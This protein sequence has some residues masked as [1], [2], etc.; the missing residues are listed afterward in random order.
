M[1]TSISKNLSVLLSLWLIL[2]SSS[3]AL[4]QRRRANTPTPVRQQSTTAPAEQAS[5]AAC[6]IWSGTIE[7]R[8]QRRESW[9]RVI[10]Q[11]EH[12]SD[13]RHSGT[14]ETKSSYDYTASFNVV[15]S[16]GNTYE[17]GSKLV[18]LKG[19]IDAEALRVDEEK[20]SWRTET[21]CFP[22]TPRIRT[23]GKNS[24]SIITESGKLPRTSGDGIM[25]IRGTQLKISFGVPEIEAT[26]VHKTVIKPFGWCMPEANPPDDSSDE[27]QVSFSGESVIIED[28]IDAKN[29]NVLKG[30]SQP[31]NETTIVWSLT[32]RPGECDG[33]LKI[34]DLRLA[35]HVFPN[36][37]SWEE[38]DDKTVD[39]NQVRLTA[40]VV[41]ESQ[42][43]KSGT[44][45]FKETKSGEVLGEKAVS[46]PAGGQAEVEL[47]WDTNGFAWT[48]AGKG[49]PNRE[50]EASIGGESRTAEVKVYPKPVV[51]VHGLWSNGAAW[52]E[53][54]NYLEEAHSYAWKAYAVGADPRVAQM[55]TGNSA[56]NVD[57]TFSIRQNAQELG[58][59]IAHT[60]KTENAWRIDL[61]A[62]SMGG[63]ISRYYIHHS[64]VN[65]PDGKPT[66][67]HLVMLGTPNMGSP[68]ADL[69][70][71]KYKA[72]GFEVEALRQLQRSFV[73]EYNREVTN[74]KG[75]KFSIL[76]GTPVPSTCHETGW[77]DG[78]VAIPSALWEV[79]DRAF[80]SR[81]HTD[82]TGREDF[83]AFVK[84]RLALGPKKAQT[85]LLDEAD[86]GDFYARGARTNEPLLLA[87]LDQKALLA[88][89]FAQQQQQREAST[90]AEAV[91]SKLLKMAAG[92]SVET[93]VEFANAQSGVTFVA[94]PSVK[95]SL[96]GESGE[97]EQTI[98]AGSA[99]ASAAFKTF[100][101]DKAGN[102]TL[103]FENR[104]KAQANAMV[105]VWKNTNPLA[106]EFV[107]LQRLADGSLKLQAKLTN[108]GAAVVAARVT[109]RI[110]GQLPE[111]ILLDDGRHGDGA[112]GDGIYGA[113][114]AK[115]PASEYLIEAKASVGGGAVLASAVL[116]K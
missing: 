61:V 46:V 10:S 26:R 93:P 12:P 32:R 19:S 5:G 92:E 30:T 71:P 77:G 110:N 42:K 39:G 111:I 83:F 106:L 81:I 116:S 59:Q 27:S 55:N 35:H 115:L 98:E 113:T 47:L 38:L 9:T 80:A 96:V 14:E 44:V 4:A 57:A 78:V 53:Y 25:Q 50:I 21:D 101:A 56:G 89:L 60:Q 65:A 69:M 18:Q 22:D 109:V 68:C 48:E 3:P 37:T 95:V 70:Y 7:V 58:K 76:A 79:A 91:S 63:L 24:S 17:D 108:H 36:P 73:A 8:H 45:V 100:Y 67:A 33:V 15:A 72:L 29:P 40:S 43:A 85:A 75:V 94:P 1:K 34:N 52:S 20:H 23:A 16:S 88:S 11:G 54:H 2:C 86:S 49:E 6:D 107:E 31:D 84:P 51:L 114:T 41:N 66:I 74:R 62:H 87:S 64:M 99:E 28:R 104:G 13:P 105:V 103:R 112:A 90:T 82:I 102:R 97:I